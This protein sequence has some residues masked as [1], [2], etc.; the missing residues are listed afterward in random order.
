[1]KRIGRQEKGADSVLVIFMMILLVTFGSMALSMGLANNRLGLLSTAWNKDYYWLDAQA[2]SCLFQLDQA[3]NAAELAGQQALLGNGDPAVFAQVYRDEAGE[4]L[5]ALAQS[6]GWEMLQ[7][8]LEIGVR[9]TI[10]GEIKTADRAQ[11]KYLTVEVLV[12]TPEYAQ[13]AAGAWVR[14]A[15]SER[16]TVL[17]WQEWQEAF[18]LKDVIEF[19]DGEIPS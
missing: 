7:Q 14:G 1:M 8:G 12:R 17:K 5:A 6:Q 13:S 18:D 9:F 15:G 3:L 11:D 10:K 19:W 16:L 4:R 2:E